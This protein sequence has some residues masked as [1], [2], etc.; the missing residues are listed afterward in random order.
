MKL[1]ASSKEPKMFDLLD[2]SNG[3]DP[4]FVGYIRKDMRGRW[5]LYLYDDSTLDISELEEIIKLMKELK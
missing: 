2:V 3:E 5:L 4:I 1:V